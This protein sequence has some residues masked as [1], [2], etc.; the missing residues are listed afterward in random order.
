MIQHD[1]APEL[2]AE[3]LADPNR[4]FLEWIP[5]RLGEQP[6]LSTRFGRTD[7]VAQIQLT[8][9]GGGLW[10]FIL[11]RGAVVIEGGQHPRPCFTVSMPVA[12]WRALRTG[13]ASGLGA[14]LTGKIRIAG[15]KRK[16]FQVAR[17]FS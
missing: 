7:A 3:Y 8:G 6:D 5:R 9:P 1:G 17:L 14:F 11:G 12:T 13:Q 2:P 10:H 16:L 4:Y 15:S